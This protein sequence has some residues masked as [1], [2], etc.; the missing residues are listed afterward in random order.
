MRRPL[1]IM[2]RGAVSY[3]T[4]ARCNSR[5]ESKCLDL[6]RAT[7]EIRNM[8]DEH[9]CQPM[10]TSVPLRDQLLPKGSFLRP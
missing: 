10:E 4:C 6:L 8:Y 3:T 1:T 5:L 9:V 2:Q 7:E